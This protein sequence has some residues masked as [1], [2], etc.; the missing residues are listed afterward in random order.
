ML[1]VDP[2]MDATL[3]EVTAKERIVLDGSQELDGRLCAHEF[4]DEFGDVLHRRVRQ[5]AGL[6]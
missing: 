2:E 1:L 3:G 4:A 6:G 5:H